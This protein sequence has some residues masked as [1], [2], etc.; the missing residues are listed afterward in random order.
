M[1]SQAAIG[2]SHSGQNDRGD[3]TDRSLGRRKMQTFRKLPISR[4]AKNA[5][6]LRI[7]GD[8]VLIFF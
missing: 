2:V 5:R 7:R 4:P 6:I 3:T 8:K 1:L